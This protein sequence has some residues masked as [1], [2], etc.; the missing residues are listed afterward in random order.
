MQSTAKVTLTGKVEK[1]KLIARDALRMALIAPRLTKVAS[2]ETEIKDN[3]TGKADLSHNIAVLTYE[4][5][6]LDTAHPNY[7]T[8]KADTEEAIKEFSEHLTCFDTQDK[9]LKELLAE[10]KDSIAKIES[11]ETKVS[12]DLLNDLVAKMIEAD[13]LESVKG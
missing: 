5:S 6:K 8:T 3:T 12:L 1:F 13:A 11:G 4:L 9:D 7:A 2:I 10:Q